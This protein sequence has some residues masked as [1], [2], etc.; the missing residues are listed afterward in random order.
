MEKHTRTYFVSRQESESTFA[1]GTVNAELV[2]KRC[3]G[4]RGDQI[5]RACK[6]LTF[7]RSDTGN[8]YAKLLLDDD[9]YNALKDAKGDIDRNAILMRSDIHDQFDD[10]QFGFSYENGYNKFYRFEVS[11]APSIPKAPAYNLHAPMRL[12]NALGPQQAPIPNELFKHHF[13]TGLLWYFKGFGRGLNHAADVFSSAE[14]YNSLYNAHLCTRPRP[15]P[16]QCELRQIADQTQPPNKRQHGPLPLNTHISCRDRAQIP[17]NAPPLYDVYYDRHDGRLVA[18]GLWVRR[19]SVFFAGRSTSSSISSWEAKV[20]VGGNFAASQFVEVQG[21]EAVEREMRR[22]L[23]GGHVAVDKISEHLSVMSD[24]TT[25]RLSG[26][27]ELRNEGDDSDALEKLTVVIDQVVETIRGYFAAARAVLERNVAGNSDKNLFFHEIG[28]VE[29]MEK[30]CTEPGAFAENQA[31]HQAD[32]HDLRR[33][34]VAA[35]RAAQLEA[36][37]RAHP[38]LFPMTPQPR[39]KLE[40]YF[41]WLEERA[42][43]AK[44]KARVP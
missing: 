3:N 1:I 16:L 28:E 21:A 2:D 36:F 13:I 34:T 6:W 25:R 12:L 26:R 39:G 8:T 23:G 38:A 19:R 14:V 5:T 42:A 20:R 10:Y 41:V 15:C 7:I 4:V 17:P 37:M 32:E 22:A 30:I 44:N 33:K 40:A 11:G 24:L 35:T 43:A 9:A 18:E 27:L 29:L 31:E